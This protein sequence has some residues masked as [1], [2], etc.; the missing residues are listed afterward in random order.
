MWG[1]AL[2]GTLLAL[3]AP[4]QAGEVR[5]RGASQ[6]VEVAPGRAGSASAR[7]TN[8][9]DGAVE[10]VERLELPAGWRA[11]T[12]PGALTLQGGEVRTQLVGFSVPGDAPAALYEIRYNVVDAAPG[13]DDAVFRV[14]VLPVRGVTLTSMDEPTR[15]IAGEQQTS[16]LL[17]HNRGNE[18]TRLTLEVLGDAVITGVITPE[19]LV[20]GPGESHTVEVATSASRDV[21]AFETHPVR[22]VVRSDGVDPLRVGTV[23]WVPVTPRHVA[24]GDLLRRVPVRA[25][26]RGTAG[27]SAVGAQVEVA[28][29]GAVDAAGQVRVDAFARGPD[30]RHTGAFGRHDELRLAIDTPHVDVDLGDGVY[31]T[32]PLLSQGRYGRGAAVRAEAGPLQLGA[33]YAASRFLARSVEEVGGWVGLAGDRGEARVNVL[34]LWEDGQGAHTLL[35]LRA[36]RRFGAWG[37]LGGEVAADLHDAGGRPGLGF[38]L[39]AGAV[40]SSGASLDVAFTRADARFRGWFRDQ[41]QLVAG[42]FVPLAKAVSLRGTLVHRADRAV[43]EDVRTLSMARLGLIVRPA[44]GLHVGLWGDLAGRGAG[45]AL[46]ETGLTAAARGTV[47]WSSRVHALHVESTA[48]W[49]EVPREG[50]SGWVLQQRANLGVHPMKRQ[51]VGAYVVVSTGPTD[52]LLLASGTSLGAFFDWEPVPGLFVDLRGERGLGARKVDLVDGRI[53]ARWGDGFEL[54]ARGRVRSIRTGA[55]GQAAAEV[56]LTIPLGV[57]VGVRRDVGVVKGRLVDPVTGQGISGVPLAIGDDALIT[58]ARGRFASGV[59]PVGEHLLTVRPSDLGMTR[60]STT[61]LPLPTTVR[62]GV[63]TRVDLG[64]VEAATLRGQLRTTDGAPLRGVRVVATD[65][66]TRRLGLTDAEGRVVFGGLA[67]GAWRIEPVAAD[68]PR[69]HGVEGDGRV[70]LAAGQVGEAALA[71]RT[72]TRRMAIIELGP[73]APSAEVL[74]PVEPPMA[75]EPRGRHRVQRVAPARRVDPASAVPLCFE[76]LGAVWVVEP[77]GEAPRTDLP[78]VPADALEDLIADPTMLVEHA[79]SPR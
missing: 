44:D 30:M 29:G 70:D 36:E 48:A 20:L 5:V 41:D 74:S 54:S 56:V 6:V 52:G 16:R 67:P 58:D 59:L 77:G 69:W 11:L 43:V 38:R 79:V 4:V 37:R 18:T 46:A 15:M 23:L 19:V 2:L 26:V 72:E 39:E 57:P 73:V 31:T 32:S 17:V 33:H 21:S 47:R 71:V 49:H 64:V 42:L 60:V 22:V 65:G 13:D 12:A 68:L 50:R 25:S 62:G 34:R 24:Q 75:D 3:T 10:V 28:G 51:T 55:G 45:G 7:L 1:L 76:G 63:V 78:I 14:R 40:A 66:V 61:P 27:A 8:A 53:G 35:G 9:S